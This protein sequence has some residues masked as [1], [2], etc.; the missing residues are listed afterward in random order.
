MTCG[1]KMVPKN[2]E[3]GGASDVEERAAINGPGTQLAGAGVR[4][5]TPPATDYQEADRART[6]SFPSYP[7][8]QAFSGLRSYQPVALN[9]VDSQSFEANKRQPIPDCRRAST[10]G[11]GIPI[12]PS[13]QPGRQAGWAIPAG[14]AIRTGRCSHTTTGTGGARRHGR[15]LVIVTVHNTR[16]QLSVHCGLLDPRTTSSGS[17]Q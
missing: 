9:L 5:S 6:R 8:A 13:L 15:A 7:A 14:S 2:R 17:F 1:P 11:D 12:N 10:P 4:G 3:A 16:S